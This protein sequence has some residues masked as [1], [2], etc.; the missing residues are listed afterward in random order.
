MKSKKIVFVDMDGTL[1]DFK[2]GID[3]L[4]E[5]ICMAGQARMGKKT[6]RPISA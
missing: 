5:P 6:P 1:V 4:T 3:T 2:S